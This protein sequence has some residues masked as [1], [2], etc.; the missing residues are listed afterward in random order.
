MALFEITLT[1]RGCGRQCRATISESADTGALR[2]STCGGALLEFRTVKGYVYVLSN[3]KMP[4]LVKI[5]CTTR[6][7][8]ERVQE[9][10]AA[11]GVPT[12]FTVEAYFESSAPEDHEAEVH[13][14]L[15]AQ[16]LTGREFFELEIMAAVHAV[17]AVVGGRP[18]DS[19]VHT[20]VQ[21]PSAPVRPI[22]T[23][24]CLRERAMKKHAWIWGT[25][26]RGR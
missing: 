19:S 10:N 3:P 16:R 8:E 18:I 25:Y 12:P 22:S 9:L 2:C 21:L 23:Q 14:R 1:C 5:G 15:G 7:V 4:G 13:R 11:S 6:R 20:E 17:E 24:G 26:E